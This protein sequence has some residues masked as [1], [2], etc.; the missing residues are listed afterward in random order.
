[1]QDIEIKAHVL[2]KEHLLPILQNKSI[3]LSSYICFSGVY[4]F[5]F[6]RRPIIYL[7]IHFYNKIYIYIYL[8]FS[9]E[10]IPARP[11]TLFT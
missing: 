11:S 4:R 10:S 8:K 3:F 7:Y 6:R 5:F 2:N 1:M 9:G